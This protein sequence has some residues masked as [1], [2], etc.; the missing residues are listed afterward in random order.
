MHVFLKA[1]KRVWYC[2]QS[3]GGSGGGGGG[4]E[5][6]GGSWVVEGGVVSEMVGC[7]AGMVVCWDRYQDAR[8]AQ[9]APTR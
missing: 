5:A 8:A 6:L 4:G 7:C 9:L 1:G 3:G 2:V